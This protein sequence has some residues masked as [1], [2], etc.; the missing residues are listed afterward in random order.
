MKVSLSQVMNSNT[1]FIIPVTL[2]VHANQYLKQTG[3][4]NYEKHDI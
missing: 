1:M 2:C 3:T 4:K